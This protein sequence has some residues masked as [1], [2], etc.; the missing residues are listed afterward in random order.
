MA[1]VIVN[2]HLD[3]SRHI[4]Q[5][6]ASMPLSEA[7]SEYGL[8][9]DALVV[10]STAAD[11]L[12]EVALPTRARWRADPTAWVKE[13]AHG[14]VWSK[15]RMILES[16]RDNDQTAV[17]TC[18]T[19]GKS[20]AA[21][22]AVCWWIDSHDPGTA[23]VVTTAPTGAQVKAILW[24]YI[25]RIHQE[26]QLIGRTNMTEWLVGNEL[27]GYGRK[28]S[29][30][31]PDA[32]QGIHAQFVL[33]VIDEACGV[34]EQLWDAASTLTSNAGSRTLAI[35]NPDDP[36]SRFAK[37]CN[38]GSGW[39][40]IQIGAH[41]TPNFTGEEVPE[42][43]SASL[44]SPKWV[45]QKKIDWGVDSPLYM[46]KVLGQFPTDSEDG[47]VPVSF[48]NPCRYLADDQSIESGEFHAGLDVGETNDR[49]V[50]YVRHGMRALKHYIIDHSGDAMDAVGRVVTLINEYQLSTLTIDVIG[51]GWG[52]YSR[53][54]E[55][56]SAH[57]PTSKGTSHSCVLKRFSA[58]EAAHDPKRFINKRSELWWEVGRENSRL[59]RWD[60]SY[61]DDDTIAELTCPR[62]RIEGSHSRVQV[63]SKDTVRQRLGRSPDLADALLMAFYLGDPPPL[64][65]KFSSRNRQL[66]STVI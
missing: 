4:A 45:A 36:N 50:L 59:K 33:V 1:R 53:L 29:E 22:L 18:H 9:D 2:P 12:D 44:I 35:G 39:N 14:F 16:L 10:L 62:Y 32:F 26:A 8:E 27:V 19:I 58:G 37:V 34:P 57:N 21:A 43:V 46:S 13:R 54:K 47:V 20:H 7:P 24:R 17:P 66:A 60:L 56:S 15:Q 23:F 63:E 31:Q 61:C 64:P 55:L 41:D 25:N 49:T 65:G 11:L 5:A 38:P 6:A 28:P 42:V 52:V 48:V 40:I 3:F 51:V 30:Y